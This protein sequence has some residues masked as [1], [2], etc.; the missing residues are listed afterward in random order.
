MTTEAT[1]PDQG[2]VEPGLTDPAAAPLIPGDAGI[3][4]LVAGEL[5]VFTLFFFLFSQARLQDPATFAAAHQTLDRDLGLLNTLL[6]LTGSL[7]VAL[8][9]H[10]LKAGRRKPQAFI[11][12]GMA[13]GL[14]F[15]ALKVTEYADKVEAGIT[16]L[17]CS[18]EM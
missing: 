11:R 7:F 5:V 17:T 10:R 9:I 4:V 16:L 13:C 3:W 15:A 8:G 14:S 1:S 12:L 18:P 6:L 2:N